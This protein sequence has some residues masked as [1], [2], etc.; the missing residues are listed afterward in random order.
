MLHDLSHPSMLTFN[1]P[2][3]LTSVEGDLGILSSSPQCWKSAIALF[4]RAQILQEQDDS[5]STKLCQLMPEEKLKILA[6]EIARCH[7]EDL[8]KPLMQDMSLI[9]D[10]SVREDHN[11]PDI[12]FCLKHLTDAGA[13]TYTHYVSYVQQ[14]CTRLTQELIIS[15]QH[16]AT[17]EMA[18]RHAEITLQSIE[19]AR[20]HSDQMAMLAM[21]PEQLQ[22]TLMT[23]LSESLKTSLSQALVDQVND[24]L[25]DLLH[26][27]L[28]D[29]LR[30]LLDTHAAAQAH[31]TEALWKQFENRFI[32]HKDREEQWNQ[33]QLSAWESQLQEQRDKVIA[34]TETVSKTTKT[35]QP[36]LGIQTLV[37]AATQGYTW[38]TFLL[39]FV[40]T[41]NIVWLLT[42]PKRCQ[43]FRSYIFGVVLTE[44]LLEIG[45]VALQQHD[46]LTEV[47]RLV[48]VVEVRRCALFLECLV[49]IIGLLVSCCRNPEDANESDDMMEVNV[50][51]HCLQQ[52]M[53]PV[54][55]A[56]ALSYK[57][58]G[59]EVHVNGERYRKLHPRDVTF[60]SPSFVSPPPS[61]SPPSIRREDKMARDLDQLLFVHTDIGQFPGSDTLLASQ[62]QSV[63]PLTS[64]VPPVVTCRP[65]SL[66]TGTF[67]DTR[68]SRYSNTLQTPSLSSPSPAPI[69]L[70]VAGHNL[71][72]PDIVPEASATT[73][74]TVP[75]I[76]M[77]L[78][79]W[80]QEQVLPAPQDTN[81]LS[82]LLNLQ[83][84]ESLSDTL[85]VD[86]ESSV[87]DLNEQDGET[88]QQEEPRAKRQK[89]KHEEL[90]LSP[91]S[92][93]E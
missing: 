66:A 82:P 2:S 69:V 93:V 46:L 64:N 1:A 8:G 85:A 86:E 12:Q 83:S 11:L 22:V 88:Q 25:P 58:S 37:S 35:L 38:V 23:E 77:G 36:L 87:G 31:Y 56:S 80:V 52:R 17:T 4:H 20:K 63:V 15:V 45:M 68:I 42:R 65:L 44:A 61:L 54:Y 91:T 70:D 74:P 40:G 34:L 84:H 59:D 76:T 39:H 55:K 62:A 41:F 29:R 3:S 9:H 78:A 16:A 81:E 24:Q 19:L 57:E 50:F 47:E 90:T 72:S 67:N 26:H 28:D 10:C 7:L 73:S 13:N 32:E 48:A 79:Q 6:L 92:S 53:G 5:I 14:L 27:H 49:Y 21:I 43:S 51:N 89:V 18:K 75:T 30:S 33:L 60:S 71:M